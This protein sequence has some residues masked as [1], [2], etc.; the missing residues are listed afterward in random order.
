MRRF[1]SF[2]VGPGNKFAHAAALSVAE[3]PG[4]RYNPV[5]LLGPR[6]TGK[7]HLLEAIAS[8]LTEEGSVQSC[9]VRARDVGFPRAVLRIQGT[10]LIDDVDDLDIRELDRLLG[11]LSQLVDDHRQVVATAQDL[12]RALGLQDFASS[13]Q[14]GLMMQLLP[15]QQSREP[16]PGAIPLRRA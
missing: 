6:G 14:W 16:E 12:T 10:V 5:I 8:Y 4:Y 2:Q 1:D 7:T 15:D 3:C 9:P 13:R 11:V